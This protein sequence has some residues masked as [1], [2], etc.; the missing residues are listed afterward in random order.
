[1][2]CIH[3]GAGLKSTRGA[4]RYGESGLSNV[5]LLNVELRTCAACG[6]RE[7]VIPK[8]EQLHK[9]IAHAVS[10]RGPDWKRGPRKGPRRRAAWRSRRGPRPAELAASDVATM[11]RSLAIER[12]GARTPFCVAGEPRVSAGRHTKTG[13]VVVLLCAH[14]ATTMAR[15]RRELLDD[16]RPGPLPDIRPS[17]DG[18]TWCCTVRG[19]P[20]AVR[21]VLRASPDGDCWASITPPAD[22]PRKQPASR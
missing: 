8:I 4:H 22:A 6:D 12:L 16:R 13:L 7:V 17:G 19:Q 1:M 18:L 15:T 9:L 14:T 10:L 2:R 5:T 20:R 11:C 21:L 3:C